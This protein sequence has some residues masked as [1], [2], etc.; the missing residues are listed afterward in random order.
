M[1]NI[2]RYKRKIRFYRHYK[3]IRCE[4]HPFANKDGFVF[5]HRLVAEK[6]L[7]NEN[8]SEIINGKKY[9]SP[10]FS[11]HHIDFDK[12]NNSPENLLVM[13]K[14]KHKSLHNSIKKEENFLNYC[15]H[16]NLNSETVRKTRIKFKAYKP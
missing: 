3:L 2:G 1:L 11:V 10:N 7:L 14:S 12:S 16:F 15:K 8:N 5:E 6:Y 4:E 9:L 13:T